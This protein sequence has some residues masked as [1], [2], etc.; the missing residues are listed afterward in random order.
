MEF[1][2]WYSEVLRSAEVMD[3]RYPVKGMYV[4]MPYGFEIRRRVVELLRKKLRETGHEEVL[5]PTLI[6][7]GNLSK[8]AEHIAGFEDE[9]YWVTHGGTKEL[10][11]RLALR[12]TSETAIYP[13]FALWIRSHADLPLK[14]FQVVNTFRYETKHTRPLI[15]MREITTF[16]EA[17]TA[18]A[19]EEEAEEQVR[20]AFE[21]YSWLFDTLGIPYIASVRPEWDKFPGAEYTV[22]FDTLMPNGRALQIGTVHMLGQ[23]FS[24]TFEVTFETE[25]GDTEYVHMTC[26]GVSD[27]V[28]AAV[29]GIHGDESGLVLPPVITPIQVAVVPIP[30][31]GARREVKEAAGNIADIL[32]D[33][34]FRVELDDRDISP[35]RKFHYWE[36]KG[37]PVRAE[38]GPQEVEAGTV[39]LFRRDEFEREEVDLDDLPQAV[40][41]LLDD[42]TENLCERARER[43]ESMLH[44]AETPDDLEAAVRDGGVVETGWC[45]SESCGRELEERLDVDALGTPYPNDELEFERCPV[46]GRR[47]DHTLRL[48]RTY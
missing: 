15:R 9:V 44:R 33:H 39:V 48:A 1:S 38:V 28:V 5:F 10:N 13:M 11:E 18:H 37:V 47:A 23:N 27:R 34:G 16:K 21:I 2:E 19:T 35:G 12:P 43:F 20:E 24:K 26:Y 36:L 4:W 3:V 46:C 41:A 25:E 14:I 45:G 40:E 8:E 7:E 42:V 32:K 17:H 31:K 30:K 22:A 6:P 29:I